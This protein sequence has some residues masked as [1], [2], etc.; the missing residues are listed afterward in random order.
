MA[1]WAA[2]ALEVAAG[3]KTSEEDPGACMNIGIVEGGTKSNVIAGH[4]F[5]H[6]SCRLRPGASNED[7]LQSIKACIPP[8]SNVDW[9]VPFRGAPLPAAGKENGSSLSFC[10]SHDIPVGDPVDFWTEA[11]LFSAADL[12]ALV[13]GPGHI[14]QAHVTDEWVGLDQLEK[15]HEL[16][17]RLVNSDG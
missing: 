17:A 15:A 12:P 5:V 6:W 7:F 11:S 10:Q 4:A 16:Y 1:N 3:Y 13:L 14:A 8:G 9:E 2:A